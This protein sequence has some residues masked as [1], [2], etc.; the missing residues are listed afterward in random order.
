MKAFGRVALACSAVI[1]SGAAMAAPED[2]LRELRQQLKDL[3][4]QYESRIQALERRLEQV[5][6]VREAS[7][8][9]AV[10]PG[11]AVA[12]GNA[13]PNPAAVAGITT[14]P[15][16]EPGAG[17]NAFNPAVSLILNGTYGILSRNPDPYPHAR[18]GYRINGFVPSQGEV[19]P[20]PRGGSLGESELALSVNVDPNFRGTGFISLAP[21]DTLAVEEA[22]VTTLALPDG[23]TLKA[24]RFLAAAGYLN[25]THPHAWDFADAPLANRVFLGGRFADDGVQL[26][27]VAPTDLYLDLGLDAGRGRAFPGGPGGGRNRN[28]FNAANV[29]AHLGGDIGTSSAWQLGVSYLR[30]SP[31][32]RAYDDLDASSTLVTNTFSGKSGLWALSGVLKWA[33]NGNAF[34][35]SAKVQ[36]EYFQR[37]ED[38][39]LAYDTTNASRGTLIDFLRSR[40]AG[41]YLQGVYQFQ[42]QWR[43]G[44]RYDRLDPGSM[45]IGLVASG[46]LAA[47]DFPVLGG[48]RPSR[49]SVMTDWSPSEFSRVRLQVARDNSRAGMPDNQVQFQYIMSLGAHG[50]HKF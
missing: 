6:S 36:G 44:Y 43:V 14:T 19:N 50:A 38:G 16:A 21:D 5:Q 7:S 2:D 11:K 40:Q 15:S 32:D 42:P 10:A 45:G 3:R 23:F 46:S 48:F 26:R 4:E 41:W 27:W 33:P 8:P 24:G 39:T 47:A 29:F 49:H 35:Q 28:G 18:D 25:E 37:R 17:E 13:A 34:S 31:Q 22:Y 30:T 20:P 1:L 12:N 9:G